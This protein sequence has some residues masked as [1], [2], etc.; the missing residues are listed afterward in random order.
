MGNLDWAVRYA[1]CFDHGI[2]GARI[3]NL[4]LRTLRIYESNHNDMHQTGQASIMQKPVLDS[5]LWRLLTLL[6]AGFVVLH[7]GFP[8]S[9][10]CYF[11][12]K[13][14]KPM[15]LMHLLD[16]MECWHDSWRRTNDFGSGILLAAFLSFRE[17]VSDQTTSRANRNCSDRKQLG[18]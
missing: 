3:L 17:N 11:G 5:S 2:H 18:R 8:A 9:N 7:G 1:S 15:V 4:T 10:T 13:K 6:N 16:P 14:L 12:H